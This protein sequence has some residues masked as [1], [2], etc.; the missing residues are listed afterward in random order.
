VSFDL[1]F[2]RPDE[3]PVPFS[4][5]IAWAKSKPWFRSQVPTQ[6][7]YENEDTGV[8]FTID[9]ED[10]PDPEASDIPEGFFDLNL[11][12]RLNFLRPRYFAWEAMPLIQDFQQ[13]LSVLAVDPQA[14]GI[15]RVLQAGE[16]IESW[17]DSNERSLK[18]FRP[19]NTPVISF[20]EATRVWKYNTARARLQEKA[21]IAEA[22]VP[23][24]M[25]F[26][27]MN[28]PNKV[29][30]VFA[31][32]EGIPTIIP[33]TDWIAFTQIEPRGLFRRKQPVVRFARAESL[34][35]PVRSLL[36]PFEGDAML[37]PSRHVDQVK[38]ILANIAFDAMPKDFVNL[39]NSA[40]VDVPE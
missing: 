37:L 2:C 11:S 32:T 19:S 23:M 4:K 25:L 33:A 6:V 31:W 8:Y 3:Q 14:D 26:Q 39:Q 1:Q 12:F 9:A 15:P 13:A 22:F 5:V 29:V 34:I 16:L 20:A 18:A 7:V 17:E 30:T 38:K 24:I 21:E 27:P 10:E 35:D 28:E 36:E 40:F